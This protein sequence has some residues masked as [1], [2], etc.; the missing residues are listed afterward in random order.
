MDEHGALDKVQRELEDKYGPKRVVREP[1]FGEGGKSLRPDILV[2][3]DEERTT[4]FLALEYSSLSTSHRRNEDIEQVRSY[5]QQIGAP[6]G[7]IVSGELRYIFKIDQHDELIEVP[8]SDYPDISDVPDVGPRPIGSHNLFE[9][10]VARTRDQLSSEHSW[11]ISSEFA[12]QLYRK[13]EAD[14][15]SVSLHSGDEFD[16]GIARVDTSIQQRH[17]SYAPDVTPIDSPVLRTVFSVFSNYDLASTSL[18]IRRQIVDDTFMS[19]FFDSEG[20]KFSTPPEVANA[21]VELLNI[22]NEE[23][24]LDPASGWGYTLRAANEYTDD[25]VGV[26]VN[27]GVNNAALFFNDLLEKSGTYVTGDFLEMAIQEERDSL[28]NTQLSWFG[29]EADAD[30]Q[31]QIPVEFDRIILD[32]PYGGR[33]SDEVIEY[34]NEGG[35]VQLHEAFLSLALDRLAEGGR[36]AAILPTTTLAADRSAWLREKI[37]LDYDVRGVIEIG[38][39][40][41]FPYLNLSLVILVID[42]TN[43]RRREFPGVVFDEGTSPTEELPRAVEQIL[44][45]EAELVRIDDPSESI[46]PSELLGMA[47]AERQLHERFDRV[48]S[49]GEVAAQIDGGARLSDNELEGNVPYLK[50][51]A[52]LDDSKTSVED[53]KPV[54][55]STDVLVAIKATPGKIY[56]PE[57][58]VVPSSNWAIVRFDSEDAALVYAAYLASEPGN[59]QLTSM[60]RG[61]TIQ[62]VPLRRVSDVIVPVYSDNELAE[63]ARQVRA[64]R[65]QHLAQQGEFSDIDFEGVF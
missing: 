62:Y 3:T 48:A 40:Q 57:Q 51:G 20:E 14:S 50:L 61:A 4:P 11:R 43:E 26:E 16:E 58:T 39:S 24:V 60:S 27:P 35:R 22:N 65:Q 56:R 29:T 12:Q 54:A 44:N 63:K 19:D 6:F 30:S 34:I 49:L 25:V 5:I 33:P 37:T 9:F 32:P 15:L 52:D 18:D 31:P 64:K 10:L 8:I 38:S 55:G 36:L 47:Q 59:Q 41:L 42:N 21:L 23:V 7:A 2:F 13:Y 28:P 53:D 1:S 17:E 46:L 45:R